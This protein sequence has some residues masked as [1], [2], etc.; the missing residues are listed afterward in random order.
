M[1]EKLARQ[2]ELLKLGGERRRLSILFC[3]VRG[4]T[5]M[6]ERLKDDPERLTT[7]IVGDYGL[8]APDL[9]KLDL[10]MPSILAA[11]TF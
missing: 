5:A 9:A 2:P 4:F 3:D 6:A 11:D 10:G 8:V 1:V 7:L